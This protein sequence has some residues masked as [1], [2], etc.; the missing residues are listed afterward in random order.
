[1]LSPV[2][3]AI[4]KVEGYFSTAKRRTVAQRLN[5]PGNL[6]YRGQRGA[7]P[8]PVIGTDKKV[9]TFARFESAAAGELA[10]ERDLWAK[11]N[12]GLTLEETIQVWLGNTKVK[13]A[14]GDPVLYTELVASQLG[15]DPETPLRSLL[16]PLPRP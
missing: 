16:P 3:R 11:A 10:L 13:N 2:A 15:V 14:E 1:M 12:R 5:N 9:R 4:A 7:K 6:I 8:E